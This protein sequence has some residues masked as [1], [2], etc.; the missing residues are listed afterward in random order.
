M[1]DDVCLVVDDDGIGLPPEPG[2]GGH[3]LANMADR[4]A[5][6]GGTVRVEPRDPRGT[7]VTWRVPMSLT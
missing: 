1:G 7:R 6:I 5:T 3:G 4:A 2:S